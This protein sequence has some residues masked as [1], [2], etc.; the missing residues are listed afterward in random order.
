ETDKE[1]AI[2]KEL[3]NHADREFSIPVSP[4]AKTV[5]TLTYVEDANK[6]KADLRK[7]GSA[8]VVVNNKPSFTLNETTLGDL[9]AGKALT[10]PAVTVDNG[11]TAITGQ[12]WYLAGDAI[13]SIDKLSIE[14]HN[15]KKLTYKATNQCGTEEKTYTTLSVID[16][17][18][19]TFTYSLS[20]ANPCAGDTITLTATITNEGDADLSGVN[21]WQTWSGN[22]GVVATMEQFVWDMGNYQN[23]KWEIASFPSKAT[24]TLTITFIAQADEDFYMHVTESNGITY[25]SWTNSPA[26][27]KQTLTVKPISGNVQLNDLVGENATY[28]TCADPTSTQKLSLSSLVGSDKFSLQ[29]YEEDA[30]GVMKK[31]PLTAE[32]VIKLNEAF[33]PKNYYIINTEDGKCPSEIPTKVTVQVLAKPTISLTEEDVTLNCNNKTQTVTVSGTSTYKW[34]DANGTVTTD[35]ELNLSRENVLSRT[36]TVVG[37][38]ADNCASDALTLTVK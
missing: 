28:K 34:T 19:F 21:L 17:A 23:G 9:C 7:S 8:T 3:P 13:T 6:C 30:T 22:Q 11:G 32:P 36:Y 26:K 25:D 5:Y 31:D 24:A 14:S 38:S 1:G 16:C 4:T 27:D 35:D 29:Y 33:G 12:G 15:G 18:D 20:N 10:L 37:Y 2:E